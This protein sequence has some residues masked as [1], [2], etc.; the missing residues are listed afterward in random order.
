MQNSTDALWRKII[1]EL[2]QGTKEIKTID[3]A[4]RSENGKWFSVRAIDETLYVNEAKT[5]KPSSTLAMERPISKKEFTDIYPNYSKWR[6]GTMP[7][8]QAKG[9]SMNSSYIFALI[10]TFDE[11]Y[12]EDIRFQH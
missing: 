6:A 10:H 9:N 8:E 1:S 12:P 11:N 4:G 7:R 2:G 3:S 5:N